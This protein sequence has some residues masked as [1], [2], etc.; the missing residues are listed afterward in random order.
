V[1]HIDLLQGHVTAT[2]L[3]LSIRRELAALGVHRGEIAH[4]FIQYVALQRW[5]QKP[6]QKLG[7]QRFKGLK[8][9]A[10]EKPPTAVFQ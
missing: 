1:G 2:S 7:R 10:I 5:H 3:R 9:T 6:V 4:K 8:G